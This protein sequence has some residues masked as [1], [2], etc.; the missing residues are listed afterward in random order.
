FHVTDLIVKDSE[1]EKQ[2][3]LLL[4]LL[5]QA[6]D[7]NTKKSSAIKTVVIEMT[8]EDLSKHE[9]LKGAKARESSDNK[10]NINTFF[11]A[12]AKHFIATTKHV[13]KPWATE[14]ND[15]LPKGD[16]C[17]KANTIFTYTVLP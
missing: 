2:N 6:K 12:T 5:Q 1:K 3:T 15:E 9:I 16:W 14:N 8:E 4:F 10:L 17:Q 7:C 11:S 13:R